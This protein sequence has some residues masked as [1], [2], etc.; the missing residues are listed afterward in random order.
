MEGQIRLLEEVKKR[1]G[2][3][4]PQ[5]QAD[6]VSVGNPQLQDPEIEH[7]KSITALSDIKKSLNLIKSYKND[8]ENSLNNIIKSVAKNLVKPES[9]LK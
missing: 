9:L 4:K 1:I 6:K 7:K 3:E 8:L 2:S 5:V